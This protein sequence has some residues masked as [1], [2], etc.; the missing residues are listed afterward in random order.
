L[1]TLETQV[2]PRDITVFQSVEPGEEGSNTDSFDRS[3]PFK[4]G[5]KTAIKL[6][7]PDSLSDG[8]TP[9]FET[10]EGQVLR[11]LQMNSWLFPDEITKFAWIV[12]LVSGDAQLILEPQIHFS[13]FLA[14]TIA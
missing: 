9:I 5:R 14:F 4:Y 12:N 3:R 7:N 10:W 13:N 1:L 6:P 2:L 11:K 8:V